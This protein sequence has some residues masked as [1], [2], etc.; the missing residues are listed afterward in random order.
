MMP[1]NHS[2]CHCRACPFVVK[3]AGDRTNL[4]AHYIADEPTFPL[5]WDA[6]SIPDGGKRPLDLGPLHDMLAQRPGWTSARGHVP[7]DP[8]SILL[9]IG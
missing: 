5:H 2:P 8:L 1:D 9:L 6:A 3:L 7:F 4:Y